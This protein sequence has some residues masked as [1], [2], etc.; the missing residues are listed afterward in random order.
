[1][2]DSAVARLP[3]DVAPHELVVPMA[4]LARTCSLVGSVGASLGE[5]LWERFIRAK[6]G[7]F[8]DGLSIDRGAV[9]ALIQ[10]DPGMR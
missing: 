2:H 6:L 3:V 4:L 8:Q 5:L 1:M 9:G 10:V 7:C